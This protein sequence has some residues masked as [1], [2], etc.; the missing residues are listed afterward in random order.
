MDLRSFSPRNAGCIFEINELINTVP[1]KQVVLVIDDTT[2]ELFLRRTVHRSWQSLQSSSPNWLVKSPQ[3]HLFRFE[4]RSSR[5]LKQLFLALC[6]AAEPAHT[7][8]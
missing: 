2:D 8:A 1:L 7:A 6:L 3:L 5:K 4:H